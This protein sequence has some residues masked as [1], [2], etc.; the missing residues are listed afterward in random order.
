MHA[1]DIVRDVRLQ[2][3]TELQKA[4][5]AAEMG[6]AQTIAVERIKMERSLE[7]VRTDGLDSR[8]CSNLRK[9]QSK[10]NIG[11]ENGQLGWKDST[12]RP[13]RAGTG[14]IGLHEI[15]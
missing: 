8:S 4:V 12:P 1:D 11:R 7:E 3:L 15:V 2:A 14:Q 9:N 6:A 5:A 10:W 13:G